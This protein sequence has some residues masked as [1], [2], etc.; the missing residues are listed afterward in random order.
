ML[1]KPSGRF[2]ILLVAVILS[3]LLLAACS[4]GEE[5]KRE[6][7]REFRYNI[8]E[9]SLPAVASLDI[10]VTRGNTLVMNW[11]VDEP[12][13]FIVSQFNVDQALAIDA[14]NRVEFIADTEGDFSMI[15]K[16]EDGVET[17]ILGLTVLP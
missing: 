6:R 11:T 17:N 16:T 5:F 14:T 9:R 12:G 13:T 2:G 15:F 7:T 4:G 1:V 3:S 10:Q 8:I